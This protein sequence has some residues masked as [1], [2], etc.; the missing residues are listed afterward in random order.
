MYQRLSPKLHFNPTN[1]QHYIKAQQGTNFILLHF[2]FHTLIILLHQPTLLHSFEG[3]IQQLFPD[4]R[5]L[6]MSSAKTIADI[7]AFAEL[8]DVKSI[9]GNPFTSQPIYIAAR[10]FLAEAAAH[11]SQPAS[12][13]TTPPT[14]DEK[15]HRPS[16]D[17]TGRS[18]ANKSGKSSLL[19]TAANTNYQRCY[20]ALKVLDSYWAGCRYILTALDQMSKGLMDPLLFTS[21][22]VDEMPSTVPSFTTPGWR[23]STAHRASMGAP[24]ETPKL[25]RWQGSKDSNQEIWSPVMNPSQAIGWSMTGTANSPA[26]NVSFLYPNRESDPSSKD[27]MASTRTARVEQ[28]SE[29][30]PARWN[31]ER[32]AHIQN[33]QSQSSVMMPPPMIPSDTSSTADSD[34]LLSMQSPYGP[35]NSVYQQQPPIPQSYD[36]GNSPNFVDMPLISQDVDMSNNFAFPGVGGDVIPWLEYLPQDVMSYFGEPPGETTGPGPP[37]T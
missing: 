1:F 32:P 33:Q 11:A 12:R 20:K 29:Y 18:K 6:S 37:N 16:Q 36:F 31:A 15:P 27:T 10:A 34:L 2:W 4:S 19:H 13:G 8:I 9:V 30:L 17:T 7:I 22:D 25:T 3:R 35:G 26:P 28:R 23:R 24:L 14:E 5:E 21:E